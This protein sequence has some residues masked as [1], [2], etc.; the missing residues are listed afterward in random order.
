MS[1]FRTTIAAGIVLI[2]SSG[3]S[4]SSDAPRNPVEPGTM[5]TV[6]MLAS[7]ARDGRT[8]GLERGRSERLGDC[9]R[10]T[11]EGEPSYPACNVEIG[12]QDAINVGLQTFSSG[13]T[14]AFG[15]TRP[16]LR[17]VRV[18]RVSG[19]TVE[20]TYEFPSEVGVRFVAIFDS[21][22]DHLVRI[23]PPSGPVQSTLQDKL[24]AYYSGD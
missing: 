24:A 4:G 18:T 23:D 14:A 13:Y 2:V 6:S 17:E 10:V 21:P 7:G 19:V 11:F 9:L 22:S 12:G 16:D 5:T 1:R 8:W 3:C 15:V 20:P